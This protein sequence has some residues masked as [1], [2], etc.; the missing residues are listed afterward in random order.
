[1]TERLSLHFTSYTYAFSDTQ[2]LGSLG[3]FVGIHKTLRITD[4]NVV[5]HT[6]GPR[7]PVLAL[8]FI[9]TFH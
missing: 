4:G 2:T 8:S 1:M 3:Y 6:R 7:H 9:S 5:H